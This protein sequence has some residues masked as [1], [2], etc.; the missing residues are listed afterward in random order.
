MIEAV[1]ITGVYVCTVCGSLR[2][3]Y[4]INVDVLNYTHS[5]FILSVQIQ[6]SCVCNIAVCLLPVSMTQHN[7]GSQW[8]PL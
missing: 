2:S 1:F 4:N 7:D 8:C 5:K 6:T 3:S